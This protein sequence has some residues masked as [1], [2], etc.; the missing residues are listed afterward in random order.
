MVGQGA[1]LNQQTICTV[2]WN[3]YPGLTYIEVPK[4]SIDPYYTVI[5]VLLDDEIELYREHNG[6]VEQN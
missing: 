1:I 6:A 3:K 5:A 2:Y 4:E